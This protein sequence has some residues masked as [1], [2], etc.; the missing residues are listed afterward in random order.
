MLFSWAG[1]SYR[2]SVN[3][4]SRICCWSIN[5][6][7]VLIGYPLLKVLGILVELL[8]LVEEEQ[9]LGREEEILTDT[10]LLIDA[11]SIGGREL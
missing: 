7:L 5:W 2:R 10:D 9:K 6:I 3:Q 11:T 8:V 1:K 4:S